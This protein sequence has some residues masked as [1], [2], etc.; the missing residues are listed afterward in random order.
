MT[1]TFL[2]DFGFRELKTETE[3]EAR[4]E[5]LEFSES[6][7]TF[8]DDVE[9]KYRKYLEEK[10]K[11][12]KEE[13]RRKLLEEIENEEKEKENDRMNAAIELFEEKKILA[14]VR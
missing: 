1:K 13:N 11:M 5:E 8:T 12:R 14:V 9:K 2:F 7:K 6:L 4:R 10:E 3:I